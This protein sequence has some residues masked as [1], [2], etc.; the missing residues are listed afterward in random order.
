MQSGLQRAA[1]QQ[2]ASLVI[3]HPARHVADAR[4]NPQALASVATKVKH[5]WVAAIGVDRMIGNAGG[6]LRLSSRLCRAPSRPPGAG[7][8]CVAV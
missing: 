7:G 2:L 1:L 4:L 6:A 8:V 3:E 5:D